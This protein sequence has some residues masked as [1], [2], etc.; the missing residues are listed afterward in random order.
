MLKFASLLLASID[1]V[2]ASEFSFVNAYTFI[3]DK[4]VLVF[5]QCGSPT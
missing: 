2:G 3:S 1:T 5:L 4:I